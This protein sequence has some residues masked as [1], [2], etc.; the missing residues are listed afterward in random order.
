VVPDGQREEKNQ[1]AVSR[2]HS[3]T[4]RLSCRFRVGQG[5]SGSRPSAAHKF[6]L[7]ADGEYLGLIKPDGATVVSEFAPK[8]PA[9]PTDL[10]YGPSRA[11][12]TQPSQIGFFGTP[13]PG[14]PNG[15]ASTLVLPERVV[16][17]GRQDCSPAAPRLSSAVPVRRNDSLHA[18][19]PVPMAEQFPAFSEFPGIHRRPH[20]HGHHVHYCDG[21]CRRQFPRRA[22]LHAQ[23]VQLDPPGAP[24]AAGLPASSDSRSRQSRRWNLSKD[25]IDHPAWLY[26]S[27]PIQMAW[28]R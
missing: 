16:F 11:T 17:R 13:T 9:Q 20:P 7:S 14:A 6:L 12:D 25:G 19:V 15:D 1:V 28:R 21:F 23:Y 2:D 26:L 22:S 24:K 18:R 27:R 5:S 4:G 3:A 10:S 8:F